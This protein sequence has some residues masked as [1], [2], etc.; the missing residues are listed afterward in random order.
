MQSGNN[1]K[2]AP[3]GGYRDALPMKARKAPVEALF[4]LSFI[5]CIPIL[6]HPPATPDKGVWIAQLLSNP[7]I[8]IRGRRLLQPFAQGRQVVVD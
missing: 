6:Y 7:L 4:A 5:C 3:K 1:T 2:A 8:C